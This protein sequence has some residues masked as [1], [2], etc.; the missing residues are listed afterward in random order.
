LEGVLEIE[1]KDFGQ[2]DEE[3]DEKDVG[4]E[5][6]FLVVGGDQTINEMREVFLLGKWDGGGEELGYQKASK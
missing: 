4:P 3:K 6:I 2:T 1:E 5:A